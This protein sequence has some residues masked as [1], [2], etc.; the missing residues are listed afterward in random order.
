MMHEDFKW[1]VRLMFVALAF[2]FLVIFFVLW[3]DYNGRQT[4]VTAVRGG[5]ERDR[6]DRAAN[7]QGWR[8]A[9]AARRDEGQKDVAADYAKIARGLE[10]RAAINC[11]RRYP[12]ASLIP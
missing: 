5:C 6:E 9:E 11:E 1:L 4:T 10:L 8:I 3:T 7:A 2:Q 12:K